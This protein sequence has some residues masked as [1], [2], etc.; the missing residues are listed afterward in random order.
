MIS[1][2]NVLVKHCSISSGL[3]HTCEMIAYTAMFVMY[4][5]EEDTL[6]VYREVVSLTG[7]WS[8]M[9]LVLGLLPSD[10]SAIEAAHPGNP[11]NCLKAVVVKW[12]QKVYN[13]QKFGSPTWRMLVEA[14][15]DPA[16]GNNVTLAET[17]AKK[18]PGVYVHTQHTLRYSMIDS[19][20]AS[21]VIT[22]G[23]GANTHEEGTKRRKD[24]SMNQET[25]EL[26][27]KPMQ[28]SLNTS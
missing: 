25:A 3:F 10:Q 19:H 6:A 8:D 17:I 22:V 16:G 15:G 9:C 11:H 23:K 5:A 4:S 12:L 27:Y 18:H 2:E 13:Y 1:G 14:V 7:N 21:E 28:D 20:L 26:I 24:E